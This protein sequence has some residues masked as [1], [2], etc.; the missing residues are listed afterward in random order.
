MTEIILT[1]QNADFD[2]IASLLAA[3][4]LHPVAIPVLPH[5]LNHNVAEFITL[6]KNGLPFVAWTD[7]R[8][9]ALER[10]ILVDTAR[11]P[12]MDSLPGLKTLDP[13]TP[14]LIVD[15]HVRPSN[16]PSHMTFTGEEIGATTTLLVEQIREQKIELTPLE[17]TL[18]ALGIYVDTGAMTYGKTTP[19]DLRAAAWL[20]EQNAALD[21]IRR[22]LSSPL[23]DIQ[24]RLFDYLVKTV[25]TR[26][27][28][29]YTVTVCAA[30]MNEYVD[31]INSVTHRLADLFDTDAIFVIVAMPESIQMVCR[32]GVDAIDVGDIV[33]KF[34]GGGHQRAAAAKI[35]DSSLDEVTETL[36]NLM[37]QS[38]RPLT[39]VAELMSYGVQ[40]V[41]PDQRISDLIGQLRRIGHE[42]YPVMD[43]G[44]ILGLLTSRDA[45]RAMEHGL[46]TATVRD[47][48]LSG[49]ISLTPDDSVSTL[50]QVMVESGWGQIPVVDS[51]GKLIGVVTRTDLI[52]HW[53]LLH[54]VISPPQDRVEPAAIEQVL[55]VSVFALINAIADHARHHD[56]SMYMVGGAVRDLILQRPNLDIDFVIEGDAIAFAEDLVSA[57]GGESISYRPF[58]TAKWRIDDLVVARLNLAVDD[59]SMPD[60]IDFASARNEFYE[61]P[62][63]LP[64]VYNSSIKLDLHR[65]DFTINTLAVQLSPERAAYR[66]LDFYS[67]LADLNN[68]TIRVLHSLSFVDDPTRILRAVRFEHRLGFAIESRTLE[69]IETALPMLRRITGERLRKELDLLLKET[70]PEQGLRTM[71]DRGILSAI[72][73]AFE[74]ADD[75]AAGFK[76]A[77]QLKGEF[78]IVVDD[79]KQVYWHLIM[80]YLSLDNVQSVCER[81]LI[82]QSFVKSYL[83]AADLNHNPGALAQDDALVSQIVARLD[84]VSEITAIAIWILEEK[85]IRE[86]IARYLLEWRY[87]RPS[88]DGNT[89]KELGLRPGPC[90]AVILDRLRQ[91][92]FDGE[93]TDAESE[94]TLLAQLVEAYRGDCV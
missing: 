13:K 40:T 32:S 41:N 67:G 63:A 21:T 62:T 38:V 93:I 37:E 9:E 2:A 70:E 5:Q 58:G 30:P 44:K 7:F 11:L 50:E 89:L 90:Y 78:P 74:F 19:R 64:S 72:H 55:G 54:P 27:I 84:G 33:K 25:E 26:M 87:I 24:L 52:K 29:G 83:Q 14:T 39:R 28:H 35:A 91:A 68:R 12:D 92:R 80:A 23:N 82:G 42:G 6:Y 17:A 53:A 45:D 59:A 56:I 88:A 66:I 86:R 46:S 51:S 73:P 34:G 65:R 85:L 94:K 4:K 1:H 18:L 76:T 69:L 77:R 3:N 60:H 36:W 71:R 15:H 22:F 16:L 10:I 79:W 81:L 61:H 31:Q 75:A 8:A 57:F 20:L 49:E 47:V 43:N 48:M